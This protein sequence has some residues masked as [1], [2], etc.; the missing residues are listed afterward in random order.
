M[1]GHPT[2]LLEPGLLLGAAGQD[3]A[4]PGAGAGATTT[5]AAEPEW[6]AWLARRQA[7]ASSVSW[8]REAAQGALQQ[9]CGEEQ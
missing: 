4:E 9:L 5:S 6:L 8:A 3:E 2:Q 7:S 1:A